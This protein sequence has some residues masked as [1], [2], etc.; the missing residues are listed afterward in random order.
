MMTADVRELPWSML[1][2]CA[3]QPP[4]VLASVTP[5]DLS[6]FLRTLAI[7]PLV[8]TEDASVLKFVLAEFRAKHAELVLSAHMYVNIRALLFLLTITLTFSLYV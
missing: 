5:D 4:A 7:N 2:P 8:E 1:Q 3:T 6:S